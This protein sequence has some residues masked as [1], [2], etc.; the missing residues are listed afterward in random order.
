MSDPRIALTWEGPVALVTIYRP[1]K[2]NALD[3]DML[4]ALDDVCAEIEG[5]H[6][7][8]AAVITGEGKAFSTGGDIAAWAAMTPPE[9]GFEWVRFGHRVFARLAE[10]RVPLIAALTG[11]ALGGGLELAA[12]A[13]IRIA[14]PQATLGMPETGLG[15]V[16]GWSGTQRLVRRFGAQNVRR[17]VLGGEIFSA[18]EARALGLVD[19]L[20]ETGGALAGA[21][22]YAE[23]VASRGP[24]ALQVAKL[25]IASADGEDTGTA[26]ETIASMLIAKT[27]DLSEGVAAFKGKRKPTFNGEW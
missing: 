6:R 11:H 25:M 22:S 14:E 15:M 4:E 24:A 9:F 20:T 19:Q 12:S 27:A 1:E 26:M 17:M 8:R 18:E 21:M 5:D 10:L 7:A 3:L 2:L 16:P 13:D 23:R